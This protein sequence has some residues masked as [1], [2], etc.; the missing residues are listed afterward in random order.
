MFYSEFHFFPTSFL[1]FPFL[2]LFAYLPSPLSRGCRFTLL[3]ATWSVTTDLDSI[4]YF[5]VSNVKL[6][7]F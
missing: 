3:I 1:F 2:S 6:M 5:M 7:I 4:G